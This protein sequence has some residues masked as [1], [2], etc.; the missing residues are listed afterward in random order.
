MLVVGAELPAFPVLDGRL[1]VGRGDVAYPEATRDPIFLLQSK[2]YYVSPDYAL[3]EDW[4]WDH[5]EGEVV[6]TAV[7]IDEECFETVSNERLESAGVAF[8]HWVTERVF[9]TREEGEAY[10]KAKSYNYRDG[11]RVYCVCAEGDLATILRAHSLKPTGNLDTWSES[12][13]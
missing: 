6:D 3:P 13:P 8:V 7:Q 9:F 12:K 10:G 5:D 1:P 2:R 11:W 4:I